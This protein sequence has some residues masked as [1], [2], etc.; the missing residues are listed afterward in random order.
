MRN[1]YEWETWS[2]YVLWCFCV[3]SVCMCLCSCEFSASMRLRRKNGKM[4]AQEERC[5]RFQQRACL[6]W[7]GPRRFSIKAVCNKE[8]PWWLTTKPI[9]ANRTIADGSRSFKRN[10]RLWRRDIKKSRQRWVFRAICGERFSSV[11]SCHCSLC[12]Q[13]S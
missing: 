3:L 10:H 2:K 7:Q 5:M 9:Y 11:Y 8:Y 1:V 13:Y 4:T 12:R 6:G